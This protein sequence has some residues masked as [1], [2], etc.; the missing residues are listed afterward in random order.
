[1]VDGS[2]YSSGIMV[3]VNIFFRVCVDVFNGY[4]RLCCCDYGVFVYGY[5]NSISMFLRF[6]YLNC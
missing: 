4:N 2:G 1:M 5:G 3:V 6:M